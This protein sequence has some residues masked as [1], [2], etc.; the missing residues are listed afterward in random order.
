MG[1]V[2]ML[3]AAIGGTILVVQTLLLAFGAHAHAD[4][5]DGGDVHSDPDAFFQILS[6]KTVVSFVTFFGLAGLASEHA[7]VGTAGALAIGVGAGLVALFLVAWLMSLLSELVASGNVALENTV[8]TEG[9]VYLRIPGDQTGPGKVT[10]AV[11]GRTVEC[12]AITKG[13]ELPTGASVR[14][15]AVVGPDILEVAPR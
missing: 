11:Q 6:L 3:C 2:Y 14:V 10:L 9:T 4:V 1:T 12:S 5:H 15:V 13:K 7:G 8:G